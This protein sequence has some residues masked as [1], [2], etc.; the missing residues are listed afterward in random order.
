[1]NTSLIAP[2]LKIN[3]PCRV[4]LRFSKLNEVREYFV[5]SDD[6]ALKDV[7]MTILEKTKNT[8]SQ[9]ILEIEKALSENSSH[10]LELFSFF[11]EVLNYFSPNQLMAIDTTNTL[12][13]CFGVSRQEVA[14]LIERG[15]SDPLTIT[16]L[17]K[18]AGGC[19]SC[20]ADI[21]PMFKSN[22][23]EKVIPAVT[24]NGFKKD[25]IAGKRPYQFLLED[26]YPMVEKLGKISVE[27]LIGHHLYVIGDEQTPEAQDFI[28]KVSSLDS[29]LSVFFI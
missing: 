20:L 7:I 10:S 2:D 18:A 29:Q 26:I 19:G 11:K 6:S 4:E 27:G 3:D 16:N 5:E 23:E 25:K 28:S 24:F 1:M 13:R 8:K 9:L 22:R 15:A 17:S 14:A 21:V 12:C